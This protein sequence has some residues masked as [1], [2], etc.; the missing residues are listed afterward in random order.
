M[1]NTKEQFIPPQDF[2]LKYTP[3]SGYLL[4]DKV[5]LTE[6]AFVYDEKQKFI[7]EG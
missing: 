1:I 5:K 4:I 6:I 3:V 2:R 7:D